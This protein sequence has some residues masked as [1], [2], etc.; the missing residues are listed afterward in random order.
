MLP[1]TTPPSRKRS[2]DDTLIPMINIVFLLLVFFMIAGQINAYTEDRL[3]VPDST[4]PDALEPTDVDIS[5][6]AERVVRVNGDI[7]V[8]DLN[9]AL[10][11][12]DIDAAS[13]VVCRVDHTLP[14]SVLDPI[15]RSVRQRS[16]ARLQI[17]TERV[18]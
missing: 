9:A 5:I 1:G 12:L 10:D 8:G 7:V 4:S 6:D 13:G 15:L 17:A 18:E 3:Q 16:I 14:A 11:V 2:D